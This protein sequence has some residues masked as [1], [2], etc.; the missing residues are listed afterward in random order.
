MEEEKQ[1]DNIKVSVIMPVHNSG[2]YLE[3][4]LESISN[5]T[6]DDFEVICINDASEDE[7]INILNRYRDIDLRFS[8]YTNNTNI[9]AAKSRN[10]GL[11]LACASYIVFLDSDD[12]YDEKLLEEMYQAISSFD[13]DI[14]L[15]ERGILKSDGKSIYVESSYTHKSDRYST[16]P[17]CLNDLS[18]V[19]LSMWPSTPINRMI[20]KSFIEKYNLEYQDLKSS[21]DVFFCDMIMI[22]AEKIIHTK[23]WEPLI[24]V[25]RNVPDSISVNRNP[26]NSYKA[27]LA[28][29]ERL[30]G[31]G[32]WGKY[33]KYVCAHFINSTVS[34]LKRCALEDA[35]REYYS[36]LQDKGLR[37]ICGKW[38]E[39]FLETN[40]KLSKY[41]NMLTNMPY[42]TQ[43]WKMSALDLRIQ[44]VNNED[45]MKKFFAFVKEN[46]FKTALWG[47]GPMGEGFLQVCHSYNWK[48]DK[49]IDN[50]KG[51]QGDVLEGLVIQAF[52]EVKNSVDI[53]I[54][55][56]QKYYKEIYEQVKKT[57]LLIKV[58]ALP[59]YLS[60][61]LEE[62]IK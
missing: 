12:V 35:R 10:R 60:R 29:K 57:N 56:N 53:V 14:A 20:R 23:S 39:V 41:F 21:N 43:W 37:E 1:V 32:L 5:Q 4:C 59:L 45:R 31:L 46:N 13:A 38:D 40:E 8:I 54:V 47:A 34:E 51:K 50:D 3:E 33:R 15:A 25:R 19:G 42:E 17:Y 36:F 16:A 26:F 28:V 18:E 2:P 48:I 6:M 22:L 61:T 11:A 58:F 27:F 52:E 62:C 44:L 30:C 24:K 9:G 55:T 7:S 49:I